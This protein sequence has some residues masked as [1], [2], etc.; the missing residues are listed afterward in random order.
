MIRQHGEAYWWLATTARDARLA[1][2]SR[3]AALA[4]VVHAARHPQLFADGAPAKCV[5]DARAIVEGKA[6]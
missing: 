2:K 3:R 5:A 6:T 4:L 1:D